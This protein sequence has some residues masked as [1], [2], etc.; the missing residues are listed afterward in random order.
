MVV[1]CPSVYGRHSG[2]KDLV[3][4]FLLHNIPYLP[5]TIN[6]IKEI[7]NNKQQHAL[8]TSH[9]SLHAL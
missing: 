1:R 7:P 4:L 8:S 2:G 6:S 9:S 5:P 3:T